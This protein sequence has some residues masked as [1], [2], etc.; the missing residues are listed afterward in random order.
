[1]KNFDIKKLLVILLGIFILFIPTYISVAYYNSKMPD[2]GDPSV[3]TLTISD[4][5]GRTSTVTSDNDTAGVITMFN[6]I[7][8]SGTPVSALPEEFSGSGF[9]LVTYKTDA[10][11]RSY[12]YYFTTDSANCYFAAPDG[13]IYKIAV[14]QA[15]EFLGTS[16]SVYLYKTATPPV[17]TA[18]GT[19]VISATDLNWFYLVSGGTYQQYEFTPDSNP[20][21]S[22]PAGNNFTFD[23]NIDPSSSNLKVYNGDELLYDGAIN[24]FTSPGLTRN[25]I[26]NFVITAS[27]DQTPECEYYGSA[28]YLFNAQVLAPAQFKLGETEIE[29]GDIVA[30]SGINVTD[31]SAVKVTFE[32]ELANSFTPTFYADGDYVHALIPF[33]YDVANGEYKITVTYGVT[34]QTLTLKVGESRYGFNK[35]PSKYNASDALISTYY[36]EESVT[37]YNQLYK[38]I[39]STTESLKYFSGAF[40]NYENPGTLTANSSTIRLGFSRE[41]ILNDGRTFKHNGIDFEVKAGVDVPAM[42]S[43]KVVAAEFCDVLGYFVV[44]DHGYG[45]KTWYAHLSEI[46]VSVGDVVRTSQTLGKTGNSGFT[47]DNRLHVAFT[48]DDVPVAP[49]SIWDEGIII[50]NF[51]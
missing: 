48:L 50:P 3:T 25:T 27:W 10:E 18:S 29:H 7:N 43:G 41:Q 23:F 14:A 4:P 15:K 38:Q 37:R 13:K 21:L 19:N 45:L 17:L 20:D 42:S 9:L 2:S 36:S 51:D 32:P 40:I 35:A 49:F 22:Y 8:K 11:E 31:P 26:L 33:S 30:L 12:K 44:V 6:S 39:C 24:A 1:M 46:S 28:S 5:E 16:Y 34:T 47:I